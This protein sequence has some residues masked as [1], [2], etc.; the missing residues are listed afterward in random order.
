MSRYASAVPMSYAPLKYGDLVALPSQSQSTEG[1]RRFEPK[2]SHSKHFRTE[3]GF[4]LDARVFIAEGDDLGRERLIRY[5]ARP[6][7]AL[8]RLTKLADGRFSYRT[9]YGRGAAYRQHKRCLL[10]IR[11]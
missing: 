3:D 2:P 10:R 5:C 6:A 11:A 8:E 9:K 7:I 1:E 4:D